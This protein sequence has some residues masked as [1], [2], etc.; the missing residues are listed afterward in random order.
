MKANSDKFQT[1][2][3]GKKA[4]ENIKS[5]QIGQTNIT[6]EE[7]VTLLGITI[8]FMLKSDNHISD[9]CNKASKQLAVLKSLGFFNQTRQTYY[10]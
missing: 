6:C 3:V 4:H 8:G 2:C 1:I 9:I 10:L 7:I 5:F